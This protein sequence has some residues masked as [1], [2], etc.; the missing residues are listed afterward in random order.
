MFSYKDQISVIKS[1]RLKDG[2]RKTMDCPFCGGKNKFTIDKFDGKLVWNCYKASCS[3]RGS[4]V[5]GRS[6]ANAKQYLSG[7]ATS[8]K[9]QSFGS[10]P[11]ITTRIINVPA[12]IEYLKSVNSFE[13][14]ERGDI[15]CRYA[16]KEDRVLFYNKDG[17]GA[18][19]RSLRPV[20]SKWWTYGDVSGGIHVGEGTHAVLVEDVASACA[21]SN[22]ENLVGVALLGT[23]I[24]KTIAKSII[25]YN[26]HTL[27]LDNDASLKAISLLRK[28]SMGCSIRLTKQDLKYLSCGEI[29]NL[30]E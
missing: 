24:T 30:V 10:I 21:V 1:V 11:E 23:N 3:V 18:V 17:T 22:V 5:E 26:K 20:R 16:V 4:H 13:A 8:R 15:A 2:D 9:K 28:V 12:A 19:G 27:I 14:F 6:V 29:R 25:K 7:Q